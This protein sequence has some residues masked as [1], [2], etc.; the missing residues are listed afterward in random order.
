MYK[1]SKPS[2]PVSKATLAKAKTSQGK[3][4]K[5]CVPAIDTVTQD[6]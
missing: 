1:L 4:F 6:D 3:G 2:N 5:V